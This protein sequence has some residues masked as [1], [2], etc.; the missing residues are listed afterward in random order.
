MPQNIY[1]DPAFF[2]GYKNLR[3]ADTGL[4]GALEVPAL[5]AVLP[6]LSGLRILDIGCGFGDFARHARSLGASSVTGLDVSQNMIAEARQLT[7]DAFVD[8]ICSSIED[9]NLPVEGFDL[10]VSSMALHYVDDYRSIVQKVLDGLS[11]G[12]RFIFSIEHPICTANPIGWTNDDHGKPLN[13]PL[14][15]YQEEGIRQ[16]KW[17]V[18]DVVKFHRTTETYVRELLNAGFRLEHFGEPTPTPKALVERPS[19][20][21]NLRRPPVLLLASTKV[22]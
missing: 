2:E 19:L 1:D 22:I 17:F 16:T 11:T 9:Y 6:E 12:G 13:W 5:R 18:D 14:D 7:D 3:Q 8:Y 15:K 21:I 4:N 20:S 10:V